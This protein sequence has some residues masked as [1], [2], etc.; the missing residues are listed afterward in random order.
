MRVFCHFHH[1]F[2]PTNIFS[3]INDNPTEQT[4]RDSVATLFD[5]IASDSQFANCVYEW[6]TQTN[7]L[8]KHKF[9]NKLRIT[10]T[11]QIVNKPDWVLNFVD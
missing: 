4:N 6:I 8:I 2:P 11:F 7:F 10:P 1:E 5:S 3:V 9:K